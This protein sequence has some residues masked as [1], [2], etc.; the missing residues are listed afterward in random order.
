MKYGVVLHK[1]KLTCLFFLQKK[2]RRIMSFSYYL[3][4]TNPLFYS[5]EDLPLRKLLLV[6]CWISNV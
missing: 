4:H 1:P 5:M 2:I 6:Q 3:A